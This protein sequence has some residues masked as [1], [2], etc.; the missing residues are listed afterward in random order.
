MI[1]E[2]PLPPS[3]QIVALI[4]GGICLIVGLSMGLYVRF[5]TRR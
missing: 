4:T 5:M 3:T 2:C 1:P